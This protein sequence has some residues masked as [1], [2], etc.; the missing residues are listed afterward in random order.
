MD[1]LNNHSYECNNQLPLGDI[2]LND[3]VSEVIY[4]GKTNAKLILAQRFVNAR[5]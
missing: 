4:S 5:R 3:L 1:N 2:L